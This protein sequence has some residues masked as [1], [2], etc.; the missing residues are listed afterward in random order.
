MFYRLGKKTRKT[1]GGVATT[2][3]PPPLYVRPGVESRVFL[4]DQVP[5]GLLKTIL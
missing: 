1:L 2:P 5:G 3:P 4:L